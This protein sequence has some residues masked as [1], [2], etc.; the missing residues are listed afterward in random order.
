MFLFVF[1]SRGLQKTLIPRKNMVNSLDGYYFSRAR[2][3]YLTFIGNKMWSW[4]LNISSMFASSV[5]FEQFHVFSGFLIL[6]WLPVLLQVASWRRSSRPRRS[7]KC[8]R[9]PRPHPKYRW[10]LFLRWAKLPLEG[11]INPVDNVIAKKQAICSIS[12][13]WESVWTAVAATLLIIGSEK[14]E[15]L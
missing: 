7:T 9:P 6:L 15:N 2:S 13:L 11:G 5:N 1:F 14:R 3:L 8:P 10:V 12:P 4:P